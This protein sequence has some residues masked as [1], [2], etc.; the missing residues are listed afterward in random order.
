MSAAILSPDFVRDLHQRI[1]RQR[2]VL[3]ELNNLVA[4]VEAVSELVSPT[5]VLAPD[6]CLEILEMHFTMAAKNLVNEAM[7]GLKP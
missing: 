2:Q 5:G 7:G 3:G 1:E 4:A 6:L